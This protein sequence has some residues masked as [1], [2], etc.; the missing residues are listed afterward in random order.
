[1]EDI[2]EPTKMIPSTNKPTKSKLRR[3]RAKRRAR[4][5]EI[6]AG[7]HGES[8]EDYVHRLKLE[9]PL[10]TKQSPANL[11]ERTQA[12]SLGTQPTTPHPP[13]GKR[14]ASST[15]NREN[16]SNAF[17]PDNPVLNVYRMGRN[18][19]QRTDRA[20][21]SNALIKLQMENKENQMLSWCGKTIVAG[22]MFMPG[23]RGTHLCP[24]HY[25]GRHQRTT[26]LLR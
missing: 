1:M 22:S 21:V 10:A 2:P 25:Q 23:F 9:T 6:Q 11:I 17:K 7:T 18:Q 8:V 24:N 14:K 5:W 26:S 12:P 4:A 19:F 20:L 13:S 3:E 15:P 16:P